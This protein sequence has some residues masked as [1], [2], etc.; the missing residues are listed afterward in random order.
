MR[1]CFLPPRDRSF[2]QKSS[3]NFTPSVLEIRVALP[4]TVINSVPTLTSSCKMV[5]ELIPPKRSSSS[6]GDRYLRNAPIC[7]CGSIARLKISNTSRNPRR[8]FFTCPK[9]NK[10]GKPYYNYFIWVDFEE[11]NESPFARERELQQREEEVEKREVE[12]Q[13]RENELQHARMLL[14]V[15]WA[16]TILISC[17]LLR[18]TSIED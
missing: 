2:A 1:D 11:R 12:V 5:E 3:P 13:R 7:L 4:R 16:F 10:E 9:Y 17:C 18:S 14:C 6:L 15:Y 8:P